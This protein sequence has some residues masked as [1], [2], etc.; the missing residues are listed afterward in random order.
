MARHRNRKNSDSHPFHFTGVDMDDMMRSRTRWLDIM[1]PL[2]F[3]SVDAIRR[4][5]NEARRGAWGEL[6]WLWEALEPADPVLATCVERRLAALKKIPWDIVPMDGLNDAE[7]CLA[8]AQ[9]RTL[10]DFANAI[11]NLKEGIVAMGQA[12]FRAYKHIQLFESE[13]GDFR[14]NVL[15]NWNWARDGYNG[16]WQWN[17]AA[18]FGLTKGEPLPVPEESIVRR[19]NARPIDLPASMLCLDRANAKA[20]WL[21]YNGRYGTPPI[22]AIMPQGI[23]DAQR[24]E[25]ISFATQCVSN[26]AGVLP[27]GS[28]VKA[29]TPGVGGPDTFSRMI[30]LSTQEMVLRATGGLMTM[31]TA[32]GAGTNTETGSA[33]QS[34]FDDLAAAEAEEI[35]ELLQQS[36][37][38]PLIEQWHPGQP[39]L[40]KFVMRRPDSDNAAASVQNIAALSAAGLR[41]EPEQ[42]TELTG[43]RVTEAP[44]AA[45]MAFNSLRVR[46]APTMLYPPAREAFETACNA[47]AGRAAAVEPP[48]NDGE[49]AAVQRWQGGIPA[50]AVKRDFSAAYGELAKAV[51]PLLPV[52]RRRATTAANAEDDRPCH[53]I[54]CSLHGNGANQQKQPK[55]TNIGKLDSLKGI[56]DR[57]I[58]INRWI[59]CKGKGKHKIKNPQAVAERVLRQNDFH[60]PFTKKKNTVNIY[61]AWKN[62]EG[63]MKYYKVGLNYKR[64]EPRTLFVT[65]KSDYEKAKTE[66]EKRRPGRSAK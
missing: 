58:R 47:A 12:S 64:G 25:Y 40:A 59:T 28:D 46:Y 35:A 61:A 8:E 19:L 10:T 21:V 55:W 32:P 9:V 17:P 36:L 45:P 48:L 2:D 38:V 52:K 37:F 29:I 13:Y 14:L 5:V 65:S 27:A 24:E 51:L 30:D 43:L 26:A 66:A 1:N 31:L 44:A 11:E 7:M 34:A 54:D 33:H 60:V 15:D 6:Q 49:L 4:A 3:M 53:D 50:D 16:A 63:K 42:V 41:V 23:S 39:V 56:C 20:Q 62:T 18:T 22:F 57:P